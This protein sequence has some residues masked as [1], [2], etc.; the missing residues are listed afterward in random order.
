MAL[1]LVTGSYIF[2][3]GS[4]ASV[5]TFAPDIP[6]GASIQNVFA[7]VLAATGTPISLTSAS[8][9]NI[10]KGNTVVTTVTNQNGTTTA[11]TKQTISTIAWTSGATPTSVPSV[12]LVLSANITSGYQAIAQ[13]MIGYDI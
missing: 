4:P 12:T 11:L 7:D 1:G 5:V 13:Y 2:T 3:A 6:A 10:T 8:V 9:G